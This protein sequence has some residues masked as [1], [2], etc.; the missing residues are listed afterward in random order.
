MK[1]LVAAL[2]AGVMVFSLAACGEKEEDFDAKGYVEGVLD[3]TYH[4]D[5]K[6]I[7]FRSPKM[8]WLSLD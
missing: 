5:Y 4:G 7:I 3:A 6:I 1:K 8:L 2:L